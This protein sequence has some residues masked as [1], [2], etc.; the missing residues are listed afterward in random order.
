MLRTCIAERV[1]QGLPEVVGPLDREVLFILDGVGGFQA[2]PL[3]VRRALQEAGSELGTV[4]VD[5]QCCLTGEIWTDLMWLRRNQ[6]M[7]CKLARRLLAFRRAHPQTA[8]HMLAFSG[9]AG[10][11]VF[12][13]ER[14]RGRCI[15]DALILACPALSPAYN[16]GP[17]M[18]AVKRCYALISRRDKLILGLGTRIFGTTDRRFSPAAG[19]LGFRLPAGISDDDARAYERLREIYWLPSLK[20]E[21]HHGGHVGWGSVSFL[22]HH[23]PGMLRGEPRLPPHQV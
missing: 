22:R 12:A 17:A 7:G 21:G 13:C 18:R 6:L 8:I 10:I 20:E 4:I 5:W 14:L 2:A 15:V 3:M 11:A 1:R 16:L 9:G 23:L 19:L